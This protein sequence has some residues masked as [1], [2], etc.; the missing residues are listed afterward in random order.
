MS[1]PVQTENINP[2]DLRAQI[3]DV[4]QEAPASFGNS[5]HKA[6]AEK[7]DLDLRQQ[8]I[9]LRNRWSGWLLVWIS[10]LLIFQMALSMAVGW[11][12]LDF[13]KYQWFLPTVIVQTF[14][15]IVGMGYVVVRFLYPGLQ[16]ASSPN[17]SAS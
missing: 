11:G 14:G 12:I 9:I 13:E 6:R 17:G 8:L 7:I 15:Q 1:T 5:D 16:G 3:A 10:C 2:S 4:T